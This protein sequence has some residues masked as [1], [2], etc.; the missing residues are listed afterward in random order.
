VTEKNSGDDT[1]RA[2]LRR[3]SE[4][5][6]TF[7]QDAA[8]LQEELPPAIVTRESRNPREANVRR[9]A[10]RWWSFHRA[11]DKEDATIEGFVIGI[12]LQISGLAAS[13]VMTWFVFQA[14]RMIR[15]TGL[16]LITLL[17]VAAAV[18]SLS[19]QPGESSR[20]D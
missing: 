1:R 4:G 2:Y 6:Q 20:D 17:A 18:R 3:F 15:W 9:F 5:W 11:E 19:R 14:S 7:H 12:G 16:T 13:A 8:G 10:H